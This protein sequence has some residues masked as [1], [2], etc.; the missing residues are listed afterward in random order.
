MV[1][2]CKFKK[3]YYFTL[4]LQNYV[5]HSTTYDVDP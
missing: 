4:K 3:P 2:Y 1:Y 5:A